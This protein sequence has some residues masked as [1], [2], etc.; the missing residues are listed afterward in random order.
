MNSAAVIDVNA[1]LVTVVVPSYNQGRYLDQALASIFDQ[2]VPVEVFVMDGGSKDNSLEVIMKWA[3]RLAGWVSAP[4][5]GQAAAINAGMVRASAAYVCWLN[6][7]DWLLP[8]ALRNLIGALNASPGSPMVYGKTFD[9]LSNKSIMRHALVLPFS[10]WLMARICVISQ[11]GTLM[12]RSCWQ[13]VA[14]LDASLHM[15]MDYDLWWRIYKRCGKPLMV[16]DVVAVNRVHDATKTNTQRYRHYQEAIAVVRRHYGKVP[17]KWWLAQ[18][19]AV[20][21]RSF[22]AR[23]TAPD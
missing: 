22:R 3:P 7:D 19:Y 17:W 6:S 9:F 8:N 15:A 12:R 11:P 14:G 18:P 2:G 1:P 5:G 20:W 16:R 23:S 13:S 4:D 21:W 10:E